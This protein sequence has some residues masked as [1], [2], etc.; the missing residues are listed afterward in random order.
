MNEL[1]CEMDVMSGSGMGGLYGGGT[2]LGDDSPSVAQYQADMAAKGYGLPINTA[3]ANPNI[4]SSQIAAVRNAIQGGQAGS[5]LVTDNFPSPPIYTN[6][7]VDPKS[8]IYGP[9]SSLAPKAAAT[10][11]SVFG[12]SFQALSAAFTPIAQAEIMLAAQPTPP[13]FKGYKIGQIAM[14]KGVNWTWTGTAWTRAAVPVPF[15]QPAQQAFPWWIVIAGAGV[16]GVVAFMAKRK[17][18]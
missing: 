9:P 11:P 6:A 7:P 8:L 1:A 17:G 2:G 15:S 14:N 10:G 18:R 13:S 3:D 4:F 16:L 12:Q 5:Q